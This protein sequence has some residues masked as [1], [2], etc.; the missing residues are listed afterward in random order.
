MG[1]YI[2]ES[3]LRARL[4]TQLLGGMEWDF[5]VHR[6]PE[7]LQEVRR[8]GAELLEMAGPLC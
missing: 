2:L 7:L 1:D 6:S 5:S 8:L 3:L 4:L